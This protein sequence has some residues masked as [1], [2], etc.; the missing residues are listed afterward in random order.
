MSETAYHGF[1]NDTFEFWDTLIIPIDKFEIQ[2]Y[3]IK[4]YNW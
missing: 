1:E 4:C 2:Y 3:S